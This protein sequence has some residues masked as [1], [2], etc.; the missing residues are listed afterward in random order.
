M[1]AVKVIRVKRDL[2][3]AE[4]LQALRARGI[5]LVENHLF[6]EDLSAAL[7]NH[8]YLTHFPELVEQPAREL[9]RFYSRYYWFLLFAEKRKSKFGPDA[10]L[11]QQVFQLLEGADDLGLGVDWN[12]VAK[13]R[14]EVVQVI[15]SVAQPR[16]DRPA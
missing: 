2:N 1:D 6:D 3:E 7:R 5:N 10:G 14:E 16:P 15:S 4:M 8:I 13:L 11:D 9:D 12:V